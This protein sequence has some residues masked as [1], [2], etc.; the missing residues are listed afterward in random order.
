MDLNRLKLEI[1]AKE[2]V[3]A[4]TVKNP[5]IYYVKTQTDAG[6]TQ[7][8]ADNARNYH[9]HA[10]NSFNLILKTESVIAQLPNSLISQFPDFPI[11]LSPDNK[12]I[13]F[14]NKNGEINIYF[15][16]DYRFGIDKKAGDTIKLNVFEN[17]N[18]KNI[19]WY[20]DSYHLLVEYENGLDFVEIDNRLPTNKY[21]IIENAVGS[22]YDLKSNKLYFIQENKLYFI[23]I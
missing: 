20:K 23:E 8:N 16:E 11:I 4:W 18:I 5:N 3:L 13:A 12:K 15:L 6:L 19:F 1:I 17:Q 7:T 21:S 14:F 22:Y 10:L 2:P 9:A